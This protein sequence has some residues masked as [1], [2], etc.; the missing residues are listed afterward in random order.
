MSSTAT[1]GK[2][3]SETFRN[4]IKNCLEEKISLTSKDDRAKQFTRMIEEIQKTDK[5]FKVVGSDRSLFASILV[6]E[7]E[8]RKISL[9]SYGL[10]GSKRK[11]FENKPNPEN[12]M[13]EN[14]IANPKEVKKESTTEDDN[15]KENNLETKKEEKEERLPYTIPECKTLS[16]GA[17]ELLKLKWSELEDLDDKEAESIASLMKPFYDRYLREGNLDIY[18]GFL[19]VMGILARKIKKAR[20]KAKDKKQKSGHNLKQ[21][22]E[23]EKKKENET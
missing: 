3:K 18:F 1:E 16:V 19:G 9:E 21:E 8:S 6:S 5:N 20:T 13:R 10:T 14:I 17:Y 23:K 15:S 2:S 22:N 7:L 11:P 4:F 12:D